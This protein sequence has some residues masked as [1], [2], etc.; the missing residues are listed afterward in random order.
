MIGHI[1]LGAAL[2]LGAC[3]SVPKAIEGQAASTPAKHIT[4]HIDSRINTGPNHP[5]VVELNKHLPHDQHIK[6]ALQYGQAVPLVCETPIE[7]N[8]AS[9][10]RPNLQTMWENFL[11]AKPE[12]VWRE[13]GGMV[14]VNGNLPLDQGRWTNACAVRL[15][16]ALNK[17]GTI[18]PRIRRKTVSGA[19]RAQ[20]YYRVTDMENFLH[21][22]LGPSDI[23]I[24]D[25]TGN[26]YDLPD[27]GGIVMMDFPNSSFTGHVT[28]WNGKSTVDGSNIGGYKVLFWHLPC[29]TPEGRSNQTNVPPS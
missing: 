20:Y 17:A 5:D 29:F 3:A 23:A 6:P 7:A 12:G 9:P 14:E 16:F 13:I 22:Y 4:A 27:T 8:G 28:L 10:R 15:S 26:Q 21:D 2:L 18:I 1:G 19:D 25:G 11:H 24:T